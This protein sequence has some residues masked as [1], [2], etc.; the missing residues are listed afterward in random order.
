[1]SAE[2][3]QAVG[4]LGGVTQ[5]FLLRDLVLPPGSVLTC[6]GSP[7]SP[8]PSFHPHPPFLQGFLRVSCQGGWD[9]SHR[10][11]PRAQSRSGVG[12][13]EP[14]SG[15]KQKSQR[16]FV[17]LIPPE[18]VLFLWL[19]GWLAFCSP[20]MPAPQ[21]R[22]F[23]LGHGA[24]HRAG[25]PWRHWTKELGEMRTC[26]RLEAQPSC[27]VSQGSLGHHGSPWVQA[28]GGHP[29]TGEGECG[30]CQVRA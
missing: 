18:R 30:F 12:R 2:G 15:K 11:G 3:T 26:L 29:R 17:A 5:A 21:G 23:Q 13:T 27:P 19:S 8:A 14:R 25:P 10:L 6:C 9:A 7:L 22:A 20:R 16:S 24:W 28:R 1:M 4:G